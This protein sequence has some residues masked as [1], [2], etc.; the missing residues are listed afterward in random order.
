M[1]TPGRGG[2]IHPVFPTFSPISLQ[3]CVVILVLSSCVF[4]FHGHH[5]NTRACSR[6][7]CLSLAL[8]LAGFRLMVYFSISS[9]VVCSS[10]ANGA[11]QA[12]YERVVID[13]GGLLGE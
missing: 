6:L 4:A 8:L 2:R 1:S 13:V 9:H 3:V 12:L 5:Q 7:F 11:Q 10:C